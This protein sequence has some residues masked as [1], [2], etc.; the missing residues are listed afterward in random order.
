M[1]GTDMSSIS[2]ALKRVYDDYVEKQQNLK[3]R[4]IDEIAKG[5]QKY[6]AGG[7]GFFGAINDYGNESVGAINETEAFR[8]IDNENYVQWKVQPKVLVA[9][10][11]FSGLSAAAAEGDDESFINVVVDA[12]DSAR[13]RLLKDE[14]R[15]FYGLGTGLLCKLGGA[16][17][18]ANTS[19]SVDTAQYLRRNMVV[20]IHAAGS[21]TRTVA[22]MRLSDVDKINNV[23]Y[24]SF[25][26]VVTLG[27][28][29]EVTKEN[30]RQSSPA[31][32]G[33]ECMGLRGI[34]DDAT[35]LTT[36]QNVDAS[37][38][39]IW[40]GRR[41]DASSA[42]LTSDL[43]Q[44]LIDDVAVLS[45]EEPDTLIM[46]KKQRRKYLDILVPE[47]RYMEG[48]LDAGFSKLS[49]NGLELWLDIDCQDDTVYA[50]QKKLIRK[51]EVK[52][53]GMGQHEGSD[54][55]LRATG[56]DKY[57]GF[58]SHY[59]NYGTS[60]RIAHGKIVSLAKP[61]GVS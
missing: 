52:P 57:E 36:F 40:R 33:K 39:R 58:W 24:A 45:G 4:A 26:T 28:T 46:H 3:A 44:R 6:N 42:N 32:D 43:L 22:S 38:S 14:N 53:L 5:L 48:K 12:L 21:N 16:V 7:E 49:F 47:K 59:V 55:F 37:A 60:K 34:V 13:D 9:P 17:T 29:H 50:I 56:Y 25:T 61:T 31:A 1:A 30:I 27:A 19:F 23:V 8:S 20:D 54:K 2:G 15:Q 51:F 11:S 35:D 18:S 41:I 10:I